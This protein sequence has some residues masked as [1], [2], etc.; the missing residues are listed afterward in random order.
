MMP[1]ASIKKH[2]LN[3]DTVPTFF[4]KKA[5]LDWKSVRPLVFISKRST[6][7]EQIL[8][9]KVLWLFAQKSADA[10]REP[11]VL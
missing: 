8:S 7:G 6:D 4:I 11:I 2:K 9:A 3:S 5:N 10:K 1:A